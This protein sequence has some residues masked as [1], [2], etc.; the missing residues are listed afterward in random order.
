M[1]TNRISKWLYLVVL[2]IVASLS[3]GSDDGEAPRPEIPVVSGLELTVS[4]SFTVAG[5]NKPVLLT[6][7]ATDSKG[8]EM[9]NPTYSILVD[10]EDKGQISAFK[11]DESGSFELKA[12]SGQV[13][14]NAITVHV[15][16]NKTYEAKSYR[17]IFHI[18]HDGEPL[19]Q[20]YNIPAN[21]IDYQMGLLEK[22]FEQSSNLTPNSALPN[23][24][25]E[26]ATTDPEGNLLAEPG[27]NRFQ[28]PDQSASILFQDWMWDHYWD[29][30]Y[31]I[32]VWVGDTKNG[33]SWGIYPEFACTDT[34]IPEG[35][36][37]TSSADVHRLEG[38]AL[39]LDNLYTE[40][41]VF[42]HEMGHVFGLFHIFSG[43]EC[44]TDVDFC[45]DTHQ[46]NRD[47]YEGAPTAHV[48]TSCQGKEFISYNVM[49]YWQQLNGARD[50]SY[51]QVERIRAVVDRG[52]WRGSKSL[53][54]GT[55]RDMSALRNGG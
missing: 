41:W 24:D 20:G 52:L 32:N 7:K 26:L 14:S 55:P 22:V 5:H 28:R 36:G 21:R 12:V 23:I 18:V 37:C 44:E 1:I 29:P 2:G 19:G 11:S 45:E 9:F 38:I 54:D 49:D 13:E 40:N 35:L 16:E 27:I 10:G 50:L 46:Y 34:E 3:C 8:S 25:F 47:V 31:Y 4:E 17:V 33:Y 15:R 48:R 30:D 6:I 51:D 39:E 53:Q 42:P 43:S